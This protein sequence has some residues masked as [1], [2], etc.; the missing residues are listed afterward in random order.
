MIETEQLI[1]N[2]VQCKACDEILT[3][4]YGHDYKTCSCPNET[5]V[6]GGN[7]YQRYGG[8]NLTLVD[9]SLSVYLSEDHFVNREA[10]C[11]GNRGK[12]GKSPLS[13]KSV[14]EM[15]N[16]H[17]ENIIKDMSG[18]MAPWLEKIILQE[19]HYRSGN[20]IVIAD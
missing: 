11:W 2:R 6:D 10:A 16:D 4:Y 8:V 5:M 7:N 12:D 17:L 9:T 14:A 13:Y 15:S 1:L 18:K 19:L 3:S 20:K